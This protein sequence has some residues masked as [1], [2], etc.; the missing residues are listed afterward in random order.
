M[1]RPQP[2]V[3]GF[4]P[5]P[6]LDGTISISHQHHSLPRSRFI[7]RRANIVEYLR[8]VFSHWQ[9]C[10]EGGICSLPHVNS[11]Q[12]LGNAITSCIKEQ[13]MNL[14]TKIYAHLC[15]MFC[16]SASH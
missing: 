7:P 2:L 14:G 4:G 11:D 10:T 3:L 8:F 5:R 6:V 15:C 16:V 12:M 1:Y 13:E 9:R